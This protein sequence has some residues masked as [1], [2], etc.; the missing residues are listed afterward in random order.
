MAEKRKM[1]NVK[2]S[3]MIFINS[4]SND[5]WMKSLKSYEAELKIHKKVADN[6]AGGAR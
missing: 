3:G 1:K 4:E 6:T 2:S 5:D